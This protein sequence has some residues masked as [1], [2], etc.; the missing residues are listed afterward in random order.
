MFVTNAAVRSARCRSIPERAELVTWA[1]QVFASGQWTT[2]QFHRELVRRG[3]NTPPSPSRP[4]KPIGLS[5][6]HRIF[7]NPHYKGDVRYKGATYK[8]THE[9]RAP[10]EVWYPV[11]PMLDA[12]KSAADATQIHDHYSKGTVYCGQCG[13]RLLICQSR[14]RHGKVYPYFV[15]SGRRGDRSDGTNR[16]GSSRTWSD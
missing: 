2:T 13:S 5:N 12:H 7:T 16:P 6:V 1:L 11:Q 8:G 15:C 14:N 10:R 9:A 3:L 4:P